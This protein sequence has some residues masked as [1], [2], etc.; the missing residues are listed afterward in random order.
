MSVAEKIRPS[1][2]LAIVETLTAEVVFAPGGVDAILEKITAEVQSFK[3]DISTPSGRDQIRSLAFKVARSK[4]ALDELGKNLV[5]DLKKQT[6]A[7]DAER[8]RIRDD[9]D[10]LKDEVRQPLTDWE[11]ADKERIEAHEKAILDMEALLD[12]GGQEPSATQLQERITILAERQPRQWQ[13]FVQRASDVALRV[14]KRL[15]DLHGAAVR[16]EAER[17]ELDRLRQAQAEREQRE[18]DERIAAAAADRARIEAEAKAES[19]A[20]AAALAAAQERERIEKEAADANA[21]AEQAERGRLRAIEDERKR[22]ADAAAKEAAETAK[23]EADKKHKANINNQVLAALVL[24]T[25]GDGSKS[26][27]KEQAT[28]IVTALAQGKIPH[29]RISY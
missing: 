17:A 15:E 21:R 13:E 19:A 23:R 27:S 18:R 28:A 11:N 5:A 25:A 3:G 14:G 8:R 24:A 12:F 2:D 29:T 1:T 10:A 6:G 9:L 4:T 16:R 7:I 20:R 26:L 22:V